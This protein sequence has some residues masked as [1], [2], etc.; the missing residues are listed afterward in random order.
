[1]SNN[2]QL[3]IAVIKY[4]P[5]RLT[6]GAARTAW[7]RSGWAAQQQGQQLRRPIDCGGSGSGR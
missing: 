5:P 4:G 6:T 7:R 1:M 2:Q 3:I